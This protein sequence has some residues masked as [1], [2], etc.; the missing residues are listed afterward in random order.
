MPDFHAVLSSVEDRLAAVA[1]R[2]EELERQCADVVREYD[3]LAGT[4]STMKEHAALAGQPSSAE[5]SVDP[6]V[7]GRVLDALVG[8]SANSRATLLRHFRPLGV[9]ENTVDSAIT[10][11]K[12]R[13]AIRQR[14]KILLPTESSSPPSV[15]QS[16]QPSAVSGVVQERADRGAVRVEA[17]PVRAPRAAAVAIPDEDSADAAPAPRASTAD[18]PSKRDADRPSYRDQVLDAVVALGPAPR[19]ALVEYLG[20]RGLL[21]GRVDTA[22]SGLTRLGR[23]ERRP[24]GAYVVAVGRDAPS[25]PPDVSQGL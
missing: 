12:K 22:L 19:S 2:R 13:G 6:P 10:R 11:L 3:R 20:P 8:S 14:G 17:D 7:T 25:R 16:P 1:R 23:L 9:K 18:R 15:A 24:D 5:A 21:A 4:V